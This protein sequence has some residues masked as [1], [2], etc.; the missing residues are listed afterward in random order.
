MM[1]PVSR[2]N[3][4]GKPW[5]V[6]LD[7]DA[8]NEVDDQFA[9]AHAALSP[10]RI[11]LEGLG[12]APFVRDG[13]SVQESMEA[14]LDEICR[15]MSLIPSSDPPIYSGA[16]RMLES[17]DDAVESP[18]ADKIVELGMDGGDPLLVISIGAA[19][20][21]ASALNIEP[22]LV[23]KI[24]V[25]WLGGNAIEWP[26]AAEYNLQ[27]DPHASRILLDSG[28]DL[29][30]APAL[31]VTSQLLVSLSQLEAD[32]EQTGP[33]GQYLTQI[34]RD[35][36]PD[37][38]AYAKEMWDVASTAWAINP[39]WMP[40]KTVPSPILTEDLQYRTQPDRHLVRFGYWVERNAIF[41]DL[42]TKIAQ[43]K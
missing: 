24:G 17:C 20:N 23:G 42:F 41:K 29:L 5:R 2:L 16:D 18:V 33:L 10:D 30:V 31:G 27:G 34:V 28:V 38:F 8:A 13:L 21:L 1:E 26:W 35:F 25:V 12:A 7:T 6:F 15:V 39:D 32:L 4:E 43:N 19:T 22:G 9:I 40:S 3:P 14:S 37:H 36:H 11:R